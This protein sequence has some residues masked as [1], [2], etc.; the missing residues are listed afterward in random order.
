M[1]KGIVMAQINK[2][3]FAINSNVSFKGTTN[4]FS[5]SSSTIGN[6]T[7]LIAHTNEMR[8]NLIPGKFLKPIFLLLKLR[9]GTL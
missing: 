8:N 4:L 5:L 9:N 6:R 3:L 2:N 7:Q 1:S